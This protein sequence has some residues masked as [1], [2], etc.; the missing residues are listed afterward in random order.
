MGN[1]SSSAAP[2]TSEPKPSVDVP[3]NAGS[4]REASS[5]A[6]GPPYPLH[7]PLPADLSHPDADVSKHVPILLKIFPETT[8]V[9]NCFIHLHFSP[10]TI[11]DEQGTGKLFIFPLPGTGNTSFHL[12]PDIGGS[13]GS[14][15]SGNFAELAETIHREMV[16][17]FPD[18]N[19]VEYIGDTSNGAVR[20]VL[21]DDVNPAQ[22][23]GRL[24][25]RIANRWGFYVFEKDLHLVEAARREGSPDAQTDYIDAAD[26]STDADGHFANETLPQDTVRPNSPLGDAGDEEL[27]IMESGYLSTSS[28]STRP[29]EGLRIATSWKPT[30]NG[31]S[32]HHDLKGEV[33]DWWWLGQEFAGDA[34]D[35]K[36]AVPGAYGSPIVNKHGRAV[37]FLQWHCV[38]GK[39]SRLHG[40][41]SARQYTLGGRRL[42][43]PE[44]TKA[45]GLM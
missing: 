18:L 13:V 41:I 16:D 33:Y 25:G 9:S 6:Y 17:R 15:E 2:G 21:A 4:E 44:P 24:P 10:F 27:K 19:V 30:Q 31:S 5:T 1:K 45:P 12:R 37:G 29:L 23:N 8:E 26:V 39:W 11:T 38:E 20:I 7:I 3:T 34:G 28:T 36:A 40:A 43:A 42:S 22:F 32:P 35:P 14:M